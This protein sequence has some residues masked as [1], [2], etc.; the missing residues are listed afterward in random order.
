MEV[1]RYKVIGKNSVTNRKKTLHI[2]TFDKNAIPVLAEAQG[3]L[4]PYEI[5]AFPMERITIRQLEYAARLGVPIPLE[6][7]KVEA[8]SWLTAEENED[9]DWFQ[10]NSRGESIHRT[11]ES[12]WAGW[13]KT[14]HAERP[15][16]NRQNVAK[17]ERNKPIELEID[18]MAAT[19]KDISCE[20]QLATT[21]ER[22]YCVNFYQN[23]KPCKHMYRLAHELGKIDLYNLPEAPVVTRSAP[24]NSEQ[25]KDNH[26]ILAGLFG[27][28]LEGFFSKP[29]SNKRR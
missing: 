28:F 15:Q 22:C 26:S 1:P 21:L 23:A 4:P 25:T 5:E 11:P 2:A 9:I 20:N 13:P 12:G 10:F 14:L 6:A 24:A 18:C 29:K 19:F 8:S 7:S 3:L 17:N 27:A 16:W